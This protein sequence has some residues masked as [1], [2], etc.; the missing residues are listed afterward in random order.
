MDKASHYLEMAKNRG[1]RTIPMCERSLAGYYREVGNYAEAIAAL[2]PSISPKR[3][4]LRNWPTPI[5]WMAN[6]TSP[7]G[8]TRRRPTTRRT[9]WACQLSPP[10]PR[11]RRA[12]SRKRVLFSRAPRGSTANS[13]RLHAIRGEIAQLEDR[14]QDAVKEY[15]AAV[16]HLPSAPAEGPLYGIQLH[17]D[18]FALDRGL[19]PTTRLRN[20]NWRLRRTKSRAW[21]VRAPRSR[22]ISAPASADRACLGRCRRRV[23]RYQA[24]AGRRSWRCAP[25]SSSTATS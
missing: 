6:S 8:C 3:T 24:S 16:A 13:Y 18:L 19:S 23:D 4:S 15:Q 25:I 5:G 14:D 21:T 7:H 2:N 1:I 11:W 9:T 10:R 22:R 17:M 12:Y 20:S